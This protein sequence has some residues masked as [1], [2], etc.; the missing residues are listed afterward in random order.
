M[1][2]IFFFVKPSSPI[3][4]STSASSPSITFLFLLPTITSSTTSNAPS[5]RISDVASI[6]WSK[7]MYTSLFGSRRDVLHNANTS[8]SFKI[9][10]NH[11]Q[12]LFLIPNKTH[13]ETHYIHHK[14]YTSH[15][16]STHSLGHSPITWVTLFTLH[17]HQNLTLGSCLSSSS[18]HTKISKVHDNPKSN[19]TV[20]RYIIMATDKAKVGMSRTTHGSI[21]LSQNIKRKSTKGQFV[22]T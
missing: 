18:T 15:G 19:A 2:I 6:T 17:I 5:M 16:Q 10:L 13:F 20:C 21:S 7:Y 12:T 9:K 1:T 22:I 4:S 8:S 11:P 3:Q 14:P